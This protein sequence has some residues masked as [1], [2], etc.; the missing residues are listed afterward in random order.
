MTVELDGAVCVVT[1]ASSGIGAATARL[2]AAEG[3]AVVLAAR[4]SE[5]I[6]ALARELPR[7]LAVPTDVTAGGELERLVQL[8][9]SAFGEIDVFVSNAGQGLH[10]P[11]QQIDADD[12]RAVFE[13]NVVA[14]LRAMQLVLP[15]MRERGRG[16]IVNVSSATALRI[17]PGIGGYSATKAALGV[18]SESARLENAESGVRISVVYPSVTATEFHQHL[19]AGQIL[20]SARGMVPDPPELAAAAIL[21]AIR[22][23]EGHVM[24]ADPPRVV[25]PPVGAAA[26]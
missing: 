24:V 18:L 13:L 4:R 16:A 25:G 12:L 7:A 17:F 19:R 3:A 20:G 22:T 6:E 10:V 23:G 2:L 14:P 11:V 15:T 9:T 21:F 26:H 5:R 1:G 8:A